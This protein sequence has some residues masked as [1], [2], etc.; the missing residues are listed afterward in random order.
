MKTLVVSMPKSLDRRAHINRH[1]PNRGVFDYTFIDA[2]DGGKKYENRVKACFDSH[3]EAMKTITGPDPVMILEDD[4]HLNDNFGYRLHNIM[5]ILPKDWEIAVL[6]Y[7]IEEPHFHS[8]TVNE[9]WRIHTTGRFSSTA[10][11][12]IKGQPAAN[13]I[14]TL[15]K[16][17]ASIHIDIALF[18]L[19]LTD[20][21]RTYWAIYP[22]A[23]TDILPS[24]IKHNEK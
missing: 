18:H 8:I 24:T 2:I 19:G 6:C 7:R 17:P 4:A 14:L 5:K 16:Q 22:P 3:K 12:L 21:V 20:Q 15:L 11:Y 23:T 10:C 1:L 9:Q 13:K